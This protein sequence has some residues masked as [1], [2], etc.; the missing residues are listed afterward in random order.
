MGPPDTIAPL[1]EEYH[2]TEP[3]RT[4]N[5]RFGTDRCYHRVPL[6]W[7]PVISGEIDAWT[8][9]FFLE[10]RDLFD[11]DY[12]VVAVDFDY[13]VDRNPDGTG[14]PFHVLFCDSEGEEKK[15][16]PRTHYLLR[17]LEYDE[18]AYEV[19]VV[20]PTDEREGVLVGV[21]ERLPHV[22]DAG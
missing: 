21:Q 20:K 6:D 2:Y 1:T 17:L 12:S 5:T 15:C 10:H 22:P 13:D 18:D 14:K 19:V 4:E 7:F 3:T 8:Y 16:Y 11:S 9:E